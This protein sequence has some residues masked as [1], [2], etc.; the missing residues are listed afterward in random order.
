VN[1]KLGKIH[2]R[3][4]FI[5]QPEQYD[6]WLASGDGFK[7]VLKSPDKRELNSMP[8]SRNLNNVKNEGPELMQPELSQ[9]NLI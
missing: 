9:G 3:M 7:E 5:V 1:P 2:N 4:R 8:V 6:L